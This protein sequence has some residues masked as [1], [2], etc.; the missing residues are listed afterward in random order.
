MNGGIVYPAEKPTRERGQFPKIPFDYFGK[1]MSAEHNRSI[2]KR[3]MSETP[4]LPQET[5][6]WV[7]TQHE[8]P[9]PSGTAIK[10]VGRSVGDLSRLLQLVT[11]LVVDFIVEVGK[12]SEGYEWAM[13]MIRVWVCSVD[14]FRIEHGIPGEYNVYIYVYLVDGKVGHFEHFSW[15]W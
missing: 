13:G 9:S 11:E 1:G 2:W 3:L 10:R 7:P 8:M 15:L 5:I 14:K 12:K 4:D 6:P